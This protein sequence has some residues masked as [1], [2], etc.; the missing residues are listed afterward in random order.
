MPQ[1]PA[2]VNDN[3]VATPGKAP[4]TP[5]DEQF[6]V[7]YSPHHEFPLSTVTSIA[8][9]ALAVIL[10]LL[11]AWLA[12]KLG[13][14]EDNRS[15]PVD[16][17]VLEDA[18]GGGGRQGGV[19]S[20]PGDGDTAPPPEEDTGTK[21]KPDPK[22]PVI[23]VP[24]FSGDPLDLPKL[25]NDKGERVVPPSGSAAF[26]GLEKLDKEVRKKLF[27]GAGEG[28][29]GKGSGG[30]QD[31]GKDTGTGAGT[32]SGTGKISRTQQRMLRWTMIFNTDD[33]NDYARQLAALGAIVAFQDPANQ[34]Q[35][36]V[37][38]K[39]TVKPAQADVE[40]ITQIKRIFWVDDKPRSV[41]SLALALGVK[42]TPQYFAMFFPSQLEQDLLKLELGYRGKTE[43]EIDSTRFVVKR[44]GGSYKVEV[45][46]Q[47]LKR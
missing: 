24:D 47:T 28:K 43:E 39:L 10:I 12:W 45:E 20:G 19:G 30:G 41:S 37:V 21:E 22:Q 27:I 35:Y 36:R 34:D 6:W 44:S 5:P 32:G 9:H 7:R 40:D 17:V 31:S 42:P 15:V 2:T 1:Q 33:G 8:M 3:R 26:S 25:T 4:L 16:A 11:G 18:G 46:G 23:N 29:G 14:M 38:R 13:W